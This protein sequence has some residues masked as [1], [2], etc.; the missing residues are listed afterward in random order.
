MKRLVN[1]GRT[2]RWLYLVQQY[3]PRP[4]GLRSAAALARL[5]DAVARLHAR[6]DCGCGHVAA[7]SDCAARRICPGLYKDYV[8]RFGAEDA[9]PIRHAM[10]LNDPLTYIR[11]QRKHVDL[12]DEGWA[13]LSS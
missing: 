11:Q 1:H 5:Y 6:V 3:L 10:P 8:T 7:C 4:R 2:R 9:T 12:E 13:L